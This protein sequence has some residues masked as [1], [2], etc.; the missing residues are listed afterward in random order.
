MSDNKCFN[1]RKKASNT[2]YKKESII[3]IP[4][5]VA[6]C[7]LVIVPPRLNVFIECILISAEALFLELSGCNMDLLLS[8][9]DLFLFEATK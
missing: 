4:A 2:L 7:M 9:D 1:I 5:V 3:I 6:T 8:E